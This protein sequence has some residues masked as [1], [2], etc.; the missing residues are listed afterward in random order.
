MN[1]TPGGKRYPAAGAVALELD[2]ADLATSYQYTDPFPIA[3]W[4]VLATVLRLVFDAAASGVTSYELKM[5]A[6]GTQPAAPWEDLRTTRA[7]TTTTTTEHVVTDGGAHDYCIALRSVD[8]AGLDF[9]RVGVKY[10]G[11]GAAGDDAATIE[12]ARGL[13]S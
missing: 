10:T 2:A 8:H 6:K 1:V 4:P 3:D 5:Q 12:S 11:A 13:W 7:G 9:F